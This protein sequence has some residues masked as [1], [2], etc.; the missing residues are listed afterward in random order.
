[1]GVVFAAQQEA[2][3]RQVAVKRL[4][5][6]GEARSRAEAETLGQ[7]VHPNIVQIYEILEHTTGLYLILEL[8]EG[9]S[10]EKQL[11]GKPEPPGGTA[12][13]IETIARAIHYAHTRGIVH[14]DLKPANILLAGNSSEQPKT[15]EIP[16]AG[17]SGAFRVS[18]F[19]PKVADFGIAKRLNLDSSQTREGD[20]LGTPSYM[21][22]EQAGGKSEQIGPAT[23]VYSLGVIL[24]EM[25]TGRV[26]LQGP[27]TLDTLYAIRTEEP[28]PPRQLQRGIPR[29]LET[30]CLKCLQK[31]P[32]R[33]YTT[34]EQLADDLQRF[35]NGKPI[36]AR[37]TP[38]WERLWKWVKREPGIAGLSAA[39]VLAI[40]VGFVLVT[41]QWR[42]ELQ[43]KKQAQENERKA[44]QI[45]A[46]ISLDRGIALAEAGKLNQGLVWMVRSL[47]LAI[48]A[49]DTDLERAA[50]YNL[51]AWRTF[52]ARPG[53]ELPHSDWV[54]TVS[55]SPDGTRLL[56]A[57]KDKT[58]RLWEARSG[59]PVGEI[60][61][62]DAPV[63]ASAFSRDGTKVL[64]G[65]G[66]PDNKQGAARLWDATGHALLPPI[67][68]TRT[69][70]DV[71]FSPDG[72]VFI[73][74]CDE[75]ARLWRTADGTQIGASLVHTGQ[76]PL[77]PGVQ[78][79]MSAAFSNDGRLATAAQDGTVKF[80]NPLTGTPTGSPLKVG[81]PVVAVAF[82]PDSSLLLTGSFDG[83]AQLWD[84]NSGR[85]RG[86]AL[87][88][89]GRIRAVAFSNDGE[90]FGVAAMEEDVGVT[91]GTFNITGGEVRLWQTRTGRRLG[92]P[93]RHPQPVRSLAFSPDS[94]LLMTGTEEP[95]ARFF[96]IATGAQ[97]GDPLP[98]YGTG[99]A[100]SFRGDG[101]AAV[102]SG[103]GGSNHAAARMWEPPAVQQH[104][105]LIRQNVELLSMLFT[106]EGEKLLLTASD[107]TARVIDLSGSQLA[108][109]HSDKKYYSA[110]ALSPDGHNY[111]VGCQ[112]GRVQCWDLLASRER[113]T[114]RHPTWVESL[115][116]SPDGRS[117]LVADREGNV[118][119]RE[120]D[121]GH[122]LS[123]HKAGVVVWSAAFTLD[124]Q[125]FLLGTDG[126]VQLWDRAGSEPRQ[127]IRTRSPVTKVLPHP[128]GKRAVLVVGG[129]ATE[130]NF[131]TD[132]AMRPLGVQPDGEIDR[133]A[134]SS[135]GQK[136]LIS[137]H[138]GIARLWDIPTGKQLG[139]SLGARVR[140]VAFTPDNRKLAVGDKEG[141]ILLWEP[142]TP[143][144]GEARQ[145]CLWVESTTRMEL[146]STGT[147]R[148]LTGEEVQERLRRLNEMGGLP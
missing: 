20:L 122:Q 69:V 97:L 117:Y 114:I 67:P 55:F 90:L 61:H 68:H 133:I 102:A 58:A 135:D 10:L 48:Q 54:W 93:L 144:Q 70:S 62:H 120:T 42:S 13:F 121:A 45:S 103:A 25:L 51:A 40:A 33:R 119:H 21:A 47:E 105:K 14:R 1:M 116:F 75:E 98:L 109:I 34:A 35:L 127:K 123:E 44:A 110:V 5:I 146:D 86:A 99:T 89:S 15:D 50:R 84:L 22:P 74:V 56:T 73:T 88:H 95:L 41:L 29:D 17:S 112:D 26:P 140:P 49:E 36:L 118:W 106:P 136:L 64:T 128:D 81:S 52:F 104:G 91:P 11:R 38:V 85:A 72:S 83:T 107:A 129:H 92:S 134:I 60:M 46:S 94:L 19:A 115:A 8:V 37:R 27:T 87:H 32:A 24:Y 30:I 6:G 16:Q 59:Q 76:Q 142:S 111:L 7:L 53:P 126:S 82:S 57:S 125:H 12:Q 18:K 78:P 130:W 3:N 71:A 4:R 65:S 63:W 9:G 124:G 148:P 43:A 2:L 147:I 108:P 145:I 28:V 66:S 31:E 79:S 141:R 96:F 132:G 101:L 131:A 23:D 39:L 100:V 80:W 143:L 113:Y 137:G 77:A 138:D 139:P